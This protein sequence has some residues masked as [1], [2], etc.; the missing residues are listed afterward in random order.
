MEKIRFVFY[1][2]YCKK[3][4]LFS[5]I[6]AIGRTLT[7]PEAASIGRKRTLI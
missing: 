1:D 3:N 4:L 2:K 5:T 6:E 7:R